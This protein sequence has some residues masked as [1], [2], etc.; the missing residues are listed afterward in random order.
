LAI[1]LQPEEYLPITD[2]FGATIRLSAADEF[3]FNG[4][5]EVNAPMGYIT[6]IDV[7]YVS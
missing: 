4:L 6:T 7:K 1:F 5:N 3:A 2:Y